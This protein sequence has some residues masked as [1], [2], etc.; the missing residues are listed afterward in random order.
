MRDDF[1]LD[2]G[3]LDRINHYDAVRDTSIRVGYGSFFTDLNY[4]IYSK[5][6]K[7]LTSQ[8]FN[9]TYSA[10][11]RNETGEALSQFISLGYRLNFRGR[12]S[13]RVD[14]RNEE[15]TLL[16]P[17]TFTSDDAD[18]PLPAQTYRTNSVRIQLS[19]IHI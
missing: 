13:L 3:F 11:L 1:F 14:F 7:D 17:F 2:I 10:S 4:T 18:E 6:Q 19:L 5:K 15:N 12:K 9:A 8:S 16:F